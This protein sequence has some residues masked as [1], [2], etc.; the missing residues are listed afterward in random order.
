MLAVKCKSNIPGLRE[1]IGAGQN[2]ARPPSQVSAPG[3]GCSAGA[4]AQRGVESRCGRKDG[5]LPK[6]LVLAANSPLSDT[7]RTILTALSE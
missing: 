4:A 6:G 1:G 2:S 7:L 5:T 3:A